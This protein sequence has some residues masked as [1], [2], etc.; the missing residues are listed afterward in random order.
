[1]AYQGTLLLSHDEYRSFMS[2]QPA[3]AYDPDLYDFEGR[4]IIINDFEIEKEVVEGVYLV[5]KKWG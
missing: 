4:E 3:M 2:C 5:Q 1:M